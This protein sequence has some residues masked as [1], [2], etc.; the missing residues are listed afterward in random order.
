M[1]LLIYMSGVAAIVAVSYLRLSHYAALIRSQAVNRDN[2]RFIVKNLMTGHGVWSAHRWRT[3]DF[4]FWPV[5]ERDKGVFIAAK[6][7]F[8][9]ELA[10]VIALIWMIVIALVAM[11]E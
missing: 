6:H 10:G 7:R 9:I 11:V 8:W 1:T 4:F 2:D 3:Q 5:D